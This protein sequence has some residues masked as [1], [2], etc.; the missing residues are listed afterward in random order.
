LKEQGDQ[1]KDDASTYPLSLKPF[2][3]N[4]VLAVPNNI[5]SLSLLRSAEFLY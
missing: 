1:R 5:K 4:L 3:L 2:V